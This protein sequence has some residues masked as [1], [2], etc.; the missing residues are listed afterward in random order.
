MT[1]DAASER[2]HVTVLFADVRGSMA[3]AEQLDVEDWRAII[4]RFFVLLAEGVHRFGGTVIQ[5]T[6]DGVMAVF[7]APVAYEDHAQRA[8]AAALHLRDELRRHAQTLRRERGLD[9]AVRMGLNSGEAV[10]GAVGDAARREYT[11]LG[12]AVGLAQRVEQV[13][14][15][16]AIYLTDHTVRLVRGLFALEDLGVF[17]LKGVSEPV[18]LHALQGPGALA[19][20]LAALNAARGLSPLVGREREMVILDAAGEGRAVAI[21]GEPGVGKSRLCHEIA[22][23]ARARGLSVHEARGIAHGASI[24]LRPVLDLLREFFGIDPRDGEDEVRRKIAGTAVLADPGLSGDLPL[25]FELLGVPDAE[26]RAPRMD[27]DARQRRLL[28]VVGRLVQARSRRHPAVIVLED[29][30]WFDAASALFVDALVAAVA[31]TR[32]LLLA[33]YRPEYRPSW[34]GGPHALEIR[35]EPLGP[36]ATAT[37]LQN[38]LGADPSVTSL[39]ASIAERT[40][41]NPFF[42]EEVVQ[43]LVDTGALAGARGRYRLVAS[44]AGASVPPTVQA[45]LAARIDRLP[46][47][48][49][50]VLQTAAVMGRE[51][52][53]GLVECVA[54]LPGD[55]L[56]PALHALVAAGLVYAQALYPDASYAFKHPLTQ[57]V[58]YTSMLRVRRA[59]IHARIARALTADAGDLDER[60][61]VVAYHWEAAGDAVEAARWHRRAAEWARNADVTAALRHWRSVRALLRGLP[62]TAETSALGLL[63]CVRIFSMAWVAG[64][65]PDEAAELLMDGQTLAERIGDTSTPSLLVTMY[66]VLR[67]HAGGSVDET[68]PF[69]ATAVRVADESGDAAVRIAVRMSLVGGLFEAGRLAQALAEVEHALIVLPPDPALGADLTGVSP[70]IWFTMFRGLLLTTIGRLREAAGDLERAAALART[71]DDAELVAQTSWCRSAF[72]Y[73]AGDEAESLAYARQ[74][75]EIA[76]RIGST[77]AR[78]LAH[79]AL[80]QAQIMAGDAAAAI[81]AAEHALATARASHTAR[82]AEP[83]G[84]ALLAAAQTACG[85]AR[86]ARETA[87][88]AITLAHERGI[89]VAECAAQLALAHALVET[90]GVDATNAIEAALAQAMGLVVETG[91]RRYAPFVH[92][93]RARLAERAGDG[94]RRT[95]ELRQAAALFDEI[96]ATARALATARAAA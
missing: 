34:T 42:V 96:G 71:H 29:L 94:A 54:E 47:R 35:L 76:E 95:A 25:L 77:F 3:L 1:I 49:K 4:D 82:Q 48:E 19:T 62:E 5:Y 2:K 81:A 53:A 22:E 90:D 24:P 32:A 31:D 6:G 51:F 20:R 66:H 9:F 21:V 41:G 56:A 67:R 23:R 39:R 91:A 15:A 87:S 52:A 78:V 13:A 93:A 33:N 38:L 73:V 7:G 89:R 83:D 69:A 40:A 37:L 17:T 46:E 36:E 80:A 43:S 88:L 86:V 10:V 8:C 27:P 18:P 63:A 74:A 61:A 16:D 30:H 79:Y 11:A 85:W 26:H 60:A 59:P 14:A 58:A 72:A 75:V 84:L 50:A 28:D 92:L 65:P 68:L 45:L 12:H 55:E 57:E 64:I 70:Y 44:P